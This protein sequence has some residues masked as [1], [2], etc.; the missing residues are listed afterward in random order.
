[1]AAGDSSLTRLYG[2][3]LTTTLDKVLASGVIQDNVFTKNPLLDKLRKQGNL[4]IQDGGERLRCQIM[5]EANGTYKRY[6]DY[7]AMDTTPS[8]KNYAIAA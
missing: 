8:H 3:L 7:E 2:S 4:K 6:A 1:M 5:Y